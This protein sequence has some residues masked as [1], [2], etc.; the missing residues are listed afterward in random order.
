MILMRKTAMVELVYD[1][2]CPNVDRAREMIRTAL[3][4]L[5][6]PLAWTEWDR[7][8][9]ETPNDRRHFASPTVLIDGQDIGCD[10]NGA[11]LTDAN[12][13]RVY[14]DGDGCLCG[15]PSSG[16]IVRAINAGASE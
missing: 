3:A 13:C 9:S 12:A 15:A 5:G 6:L 2:D 8:S 14:V 1:R 11:A 16:L 7:E 10:E 4:H